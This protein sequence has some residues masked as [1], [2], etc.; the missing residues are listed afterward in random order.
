[1]T[2]VFPDLEP[3]LPRVSKPVQY[4]GGE[5]NAQVAD[6]DEWDATPVRWALMY[7]DAYEVGLPNQGVMILY[8]VLNE[9]PDA[10]AERCYAV[11]PDLEALMRERGVPAFT[12]DGHR[13]VGDFDVLGVSFATELGY[14]N[15]LTTLDLAGIPLHAADRDETHPIVL[16]GGHAAF[17]PEPIADFIDAAALGDGEEVVGDITGVVRD[18]KADGRPGGREGLLDRLAATDGCYVPSRYTVSYGDDGAIAAVT[19][20]ERA[21]R[22]VQKRTT[23]D[24]DDWPYPRAPLVPLA[25]TVHERASVEIFRGCTR[26]CRFCQAGMITRPVRERSLRGIGEMVDAAVRASG[27]DEVGLLSLSSADHSEI[28]EITKGLADRYE[29]ANTSLSLPS[30]RVDA[31]NIDLANEISRN[32]RRSGLTFAPEGGSERIRRVINKMVSEDDL[33]RTVSEAFAQGW[34]QVKLYFMCGL[35]TEEDAD[36][37]EIAGM[38]HRVI[39]A[40]REA[41]GRNDVRCTISI[42]GFVPKPHTSFQ[43]AAQAHPDVVDERLRKLREAVNADRRLGRNVGMRYH[44]G[45]PSLIEGLLARG[46]RRVGRVIERVWREGG[47]FD[48]WSEH[49]SFERWTAAAEAEL[50]PL[51]V[52]LDWFTTRERGRDEILPWDHLDSGLDRDWLWDDWQEALAGGEQDDCRWTPCFDCGVCPSTGQDIQVGPSGTQLLPLTVADPVGGNRFGSA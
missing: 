42:G 37:L 17:N 41:S 9:R 16:M 21:P 36:V 40:G 35:P 25:E 10:L 13:P 51:G 12:V 43:W 24:L 31:F 8:E 23:R 27:F 28:A 1:M 32:G 20:V 15:M 49:F 22:S 29:G 7:P 3:L 48:G 34:R 46:D 45:K 19:P 5:L 44:D 38:A 26:G 30:T 6:E 33:I 47:R 50:G 11:W 18:W 4:V 52:S 14:T 39:R 2:S